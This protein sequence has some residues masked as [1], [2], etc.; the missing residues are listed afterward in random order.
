MVPLKQPEPLTQAVVALA[1]P[2]HF[3][4]VFRVAAPCLKSGCK[5]FGSDGNCKLAEWASGTQGSANDPLPFCR[6]RAGCLWWKQEGPAACRKC[7]DIVTNNARSRARREATANAREHK[8]PN[9]EPEIPVSITG[10]DR[11]GPSNP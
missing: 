4:E 3:T 7:P 1:A 10:D 8:Q 6:I 11:V 2:H 5:N 9:R